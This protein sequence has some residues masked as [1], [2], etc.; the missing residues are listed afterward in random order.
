MQGISNKFNACCEMIVNL[1]IK[2]NSEELLKKLNSLSEGELSELVMFHNKKYFE[3][4]APLISDEAFDK[5]VETLKF[6]NPQS[7]ILLEIGAD[8]TQQ[9][10]H[11]SPMLSLDKCYDDV[12]FLKWAQKI[13]SDLVAMP[14]IDGVA[15][16]IIYH[17]NGRLK[18][19]VTR[20]DGKT[21]ED[22][23]KNALLIKDLPKI[24]EIRQE[25]IVDDEFEIRGEVFLP[26]ST[27]KK[28]FANEFI[29][30]RNLTA[31]FLKLKEQNAEKTSHLQFF[32]YDIR[33]SSAQNEVE[34]FK[35]LEQWGFSIMPW[36]QIKNEQSAALVYLDYLKK[37]EQLDFEIDGVVFRAN[38]LKEQMRLGET[39]HHPR[40]AIAYKFQGESAQ[41]KLLDVIWSV[42]RSGAI[43][44]VAIVEPV[45]VSGATLTRAS[46][47]NLRIFNE[48]DLRKECLVEINRRG[49]VI[50]HLE[51]VLA[52]AGEKYEAP[53]FCPS[54]NNSVEIRG[55]FLYCQNPSECE[56]IVV[57]KL[58]HFCHTIGIDG[59]GEKILKKLVKE[60]ILK[61]LPHLYTLAAEDLEPLERM[62]STLA[63]KLIEQIK[64]KQKIPLTTFI[65]ALGIPEVGNNVAEM[66]TNNFHSLA[67]VRELM[68]E[69]LLPI[70]GIGKS[71]ANSLVNGLRDMSLEID[72]LLAH[73]E[74]TTKEVTPI[75]EGSFLYNKAVI[76]TGKMAHMDRKK[77]QSMVKDLGGKTPGAVS[78]HTDYL[79]IGDDGSPLFGDGKKSSKQ[80]DAEKL[81]D[82]GGKIKIISETEFIRLIDSYQ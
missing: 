52:R 30:P 60:K 68:P 10:A 7:P 36:M 78:S 32:P 27:F 59:L 75:K 31:G 4:H 13:R 44:P 43:T 50:P 62:G 19:A 2:K 46:L 20:G 22:I 35:L 58:M 69:D 41:T 38:S 54:C 53:A 34:K 63:N 76:F 21:G 1:D 25:Q 56:Q 45:F 55:D 24:L 11:K 73:I 29:N 33:D 67:K 16:S 81:I 40:F 49:G 71:I 6:I 18:Y 77:A 3:D 57:S 26:I 72:E 39:A 42:A 79:V 12:T 61:K 74:I 48:L 70:H 47:H 8:S 15:C 28:H 23:T 51:R 37:R 66:L 14:K 17:K 80:K 64:S 5:L 65:T 9:I 82:Q